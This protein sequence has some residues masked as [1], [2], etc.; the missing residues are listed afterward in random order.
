MY[1]NKTSSNA[2]I[3]V[4]LFLLYVY[5]GGKVVIKWKSTIFFRKIVAFPHPALLRPFYNKEGESTL[6]GV[7]GNFPLSFL[8]TKELKATTCAVR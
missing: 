3:F 4:F 7:R 1:V 2:D 8:C 5:V 6:S